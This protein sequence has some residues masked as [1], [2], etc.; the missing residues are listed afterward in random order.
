MHSHAAR[1]GWRHREVHV[2]AGESDHS[3]K[4]LHQGSVR[5]AIR[6]AGRK[7]GLTLAAREEVILVSP[8]DTAIGTAE[9]LEAHRTG[10]LHRA[11]SVFLFDG[12]GRLLM[13]RRA[14]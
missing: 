11:I 2:A 8:D 10:A 13:Q 3:G 6:S 14:A 12:E 5:L 9:K 7:D 1:A 4:P